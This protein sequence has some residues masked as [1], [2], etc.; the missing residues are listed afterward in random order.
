MA[1]LPIAIAVINPRLDPLIRAG[2]MELANQA[3]VVPSSASNLVTN[4][5]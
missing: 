2:E 1:V 3:T 5:G 4:G